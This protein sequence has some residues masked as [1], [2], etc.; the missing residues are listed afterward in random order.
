MFVCS[1]VTEICTVSVFRVITQS[2]ECITFVSYLRTVLGVLWGTQWRSRL[3]HCATSR[4]VAASISD[5]A[6][7]TF[8]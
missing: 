5:G 2:F 1:D 7:G 4:K 6:I 8:H 3:R